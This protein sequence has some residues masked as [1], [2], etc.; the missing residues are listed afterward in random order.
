MTRSTYSAF[1]SAQIMPSQRSKPKTASQ[2]L[3]GDLVTPLATIKLP[4]F[5]LLLQD[6]QIV[7]DERPYNLARSATHRPQSCSPM[8]YFFNSMEIVSF[9][10]LAALSL[11]TIFLGDIMG[12][13]TS[14]RKP[15]KTLKSTNERRDASATRE[16]RTESRKQ[17]GEVR[18]VITAL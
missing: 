13:K 17:Q 10:L 1:A 4:N 3:L 15:Q 6:S 8:I 14:S 16:Q 18:G 2:H 11:A 5:F 7:D 12:Y 9:F